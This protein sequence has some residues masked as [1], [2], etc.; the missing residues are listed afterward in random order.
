MILSTVVLSVQK[1]AFSV[2]AEHIR[3]QPASK[4]RTTFAWG[5]AVGPAVAKATTAELRHGI[6]EVR[7]RDLRWAKEVERAREMILDRVRLFLGSEPLREM[8]VTVETR[9]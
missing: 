3:R 8:N 5:I 7:A 2:L 6:L 1:F 9:R 4:E